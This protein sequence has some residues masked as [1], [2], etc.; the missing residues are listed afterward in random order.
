MMYW[1]TFVQYLFLITVQTLCSMKADGFTVMF[2]YPAPGNLN[3]SEMHLNSE[4]L[5]K[6]YALIYFKDGMKVLE[7]GP[8]GIPSPYQK[9]VNNPTIT[10]HTLDLYNSY[11][12]ITYVSGEEYNYPIDRDAYDL[13]VSGQVI[14]HVKKIWLWLDEIKRIVRKDGIIIIIN[15][16]SWPYHAHPVDCWRIFPD[17][18]KALCEQSNLNVLFCEYKSIEAEHF[19]TTKT[20]TV[21]GQSYP[22]LNYR[23]RISFIRIWNSILYC[24]PGIRKFRVPIEVAYDTISILNKS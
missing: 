10:W 1:I 6:E 24:I 19:A 16:V 11:P 4:L 13:V 8:S 20:P 21:P 2:L 18:M 3:Q 7:I 9:L 15:P 23:G 12:N 17:G 14:E 22:L 5:F